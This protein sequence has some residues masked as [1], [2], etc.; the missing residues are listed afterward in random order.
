MFGGAQFTGAQVDFTGEFSGDRVDFRGAQFSG[1]QVD[2]SRAEFSGA[3][4]DFSEASD[5]SHP[6]VFDWEDGTPSARVRLPE[7]AMAHRPD[8]LGTEETE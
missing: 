6:P 8:S 3:Y 2:F 1:G 7:G 5:W 4:V